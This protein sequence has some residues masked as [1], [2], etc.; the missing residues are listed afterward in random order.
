[1]R[2][3]LATPCVLGLVLLLAAASAAC[4]AAKH[5][6][7]SYEHFN[8][9]AGKAAD[10]YFKSSQPGEKNILSHLTAISA[11]YAEKAASV[12]NLADILEHM[13]AKR[14]RNYVQ[15]RLAEVKRLVLGGLPQD[16]KLLADL[17]EN[18][19]NQ[20]IRDLGNLVVNEMRVFERNTENL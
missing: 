17:V 16:I 11:I 2:Y 4:G 5:F 13:A 15:D 3:R 14:D 6:R 18:Q 8:D 10:L 7:L 20:E 1:M 12:M 19:E 9:Y